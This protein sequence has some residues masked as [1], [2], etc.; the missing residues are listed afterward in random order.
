MCGIIGVTGVG[1]AS[2]LIYEGLKLLQHRGQ[3]SVGIL[4]YDG[5]DY[6]KILKDGLVHEAISPTELNS[7]N[8]STG[9]GHVRYS[10]SGRKK[11][12]G[13]CDVEHPKQPILGI[14]FALVHNGTI[15][16]YGYMV[17]VLERRRIGIS[18][19]ED[20]D[21]QLVAKIIGSSEEADIEKRIKKSLET[22]KPTYSMLI[23]HENALFLCRDR[24]GNRP[25]YIGNIGGGYIAA[26]EGSVLNSLGATNISEV[27]EGQLIRIENNDAY[28]EQIFTPDLKKCVIE[29]IYLSSAGKSEHERPELFGRDI[30]TIRIKSGIK[31]ASEQPANADLV[32]GVMD[33]GNWA[34][35]GYSQKSG[36]P[37]SRTGLKR[38]PHYKKRTFIEPSEEERIEGVYL[39]FIA[40]SNELSGK[41]LVAVDDTIIRLTTSSGLVQKLRL[42]GASELHMR[43]ASPPVIWP[44]FYGVDFPLRN[45]L[46]AAMLSV[47]EI[48]QY[49]TLRFFG[50]D[51]NRDKLI[52]IVR[53][54]QL[55]KTD[56]GD[57]VQRSTEDNNYVKRAFL[58]RNKHIVID[59]DDINPKRFSLAY[60][61]LEGLVD[62]FDIDSSEYCLACFTGKYE[63]EKELIKQKLAAK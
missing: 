48:Q 1:N 34:S 23:Q 37:R 41:R 36:I 46:I 3:E 2:N 63:I 30:R 47:P 5:H 8:G 20:S 53:G 39:K 55:S 60:L 51:D 4:T 18:P 10:T 13:F 56:M 33:S 21:T 19:G 25:L 6:K 57:I 43:I 15:V 42:A 38:H 22:I 12:N 7:L 27:G 14:D 16:N 31:L 24:T 11:D 50:M 32:V 40:E 54:N 44:C 59:P 62:A 26:S 35:I 52:E 58:Q 9:L 49:L 61:S 28:T 45:E 29:L 17:N